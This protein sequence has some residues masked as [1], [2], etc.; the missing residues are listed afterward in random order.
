MARATTIALLAV[1][2]WRP[3]SSS[4]LLQRR[5]FFPDGEWIDW[6]E[7]RRYRGPA[8]TTVAA[9]LDRIPLFVRAGAVIPLAD[10][11]GRV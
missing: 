10:G 11:S 3:S 4:K 5:L 9:P 8:V 6:W 7:S 2:A 1:A